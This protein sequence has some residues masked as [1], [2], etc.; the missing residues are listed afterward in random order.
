MATKFI[1]EAVASAT[2]DGTDLDFTSNNVT[3][4]LFDSDTLSLLKSQNTDIVVSGGTLTYTIVITNTGT[5]ELENVIFSDVIP[6][7]LTYDADSF[8]VNGGAQTPTVE[9]QNLSYT[10]ANL[11]SGD[12]TVVFS[13]T[14]D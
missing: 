1:N 13:T 14:A 5:V 8:T 12:T 7:G 10:I 11:P 4:E 9:G 3:A 2:V 6:T